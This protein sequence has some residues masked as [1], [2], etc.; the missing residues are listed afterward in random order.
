MSELVV[1][2]TIAVHTRTRPI[3]RAVASVLRG[4]DTP[5]RVTVVAH[6]IDRETIRENLGKLADDPRVRLLHLQDGIPSPAGPMNLG[7]AS[8]ASEY[9]AVMG[10]DDELAPGAIDSWVA[11]ARRSDSAAVLAAIRH[12]GGPLEPSPPVRP[13]RRVA[14]DPVKDRLAY[15]SAPL[16]LLRRREFGELRLPVGLRSG[17]DLPFVT[18][19]WFS[20]AGLAF[21]LDGPAYLVHADAGDRVTADPRPVRLDFAFLDHI[22]GEEWAERLDSAERRAIAVKTIR[23]HVFDAILNRS[24][25]EAWPEGDREEF[26]AI[27]ERI[28]AWGGRPEREL[29]VLDRRALDAVLD[30]SVS[31]AELGARGTRRASYAHPLALLPRNPLRVFARQAPLRTLFAGWLLLRSQKRRRG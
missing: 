14:L 19:V 23:I 28:M 10:S 6:N 2:V 1:D 31:D 30:P 20:G 8:G 29:S 17:E 16:G 26:A 18:R 3:A 5:L 9:F 13:G 7:F 15:R 12:V 4:N 11:L 22:I 21:D 27:A 25:L 24:A